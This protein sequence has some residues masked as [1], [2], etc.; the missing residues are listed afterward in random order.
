MNRQQELARRLDSVQAR[1]GAAC[2]SAQRAADEVQLIVVTKFFPA[3]DLQRL[4]DLGITQVGES[5]EQEA[6]AKMAELPAAHSRLL[7]LHFVGQVQT[8]KAR[9]IARYAD[10]VQSVDRP[11][12]VSALHRAVESAREAGERDGPLDVTIQ[13]DLDERAP[14]AKA[15]GGVA[16]GD[17]L[18]LAASVGESEHLRLRGVM[19][20]APL[21]TA[22]DESATLAA[23]EVL[24]GLSA[25]LR[26]E[27]PAAEWISAGMSGDLELALAAGATHLRVG[28]AI[29]GSR[30]AHR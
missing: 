14:A 17:L 20:V 27:H 29:L 4:A 6:S 25:K 12:L 15:R 11:R 3:A 5:R 23:F 2:S 1:I 24:Q 28:S 26:G 22:D 10:V 18:S 16:P 7:T 9:A 19:A 30:P 13:V 21:H 8:N